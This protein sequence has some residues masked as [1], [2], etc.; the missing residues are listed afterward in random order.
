MGNDPT[1]ARTHITEI[2]NDCYLDLHGLE[3]YTSIPVSTMRDYIK[4][5]GLPCFKVRGKILVKR[6]EFDTWMDDYRVESLDDLKAKARELVARVIE[7]DK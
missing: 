1:E 3:Y 2:S 6:S 4:R 7:S 5:E